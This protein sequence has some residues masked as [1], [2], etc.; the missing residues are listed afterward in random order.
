MSKRLWQIFGPILIAGILV[1]GALITPW[2]W[3]KV[4][5]ATVRRAAVSLSPTIL[6]GAR[7]KDQAVASGDYPIFGSSELARMDAFHPAVYAAKYQRT[8]PFLLGAAGTQ[9]LTHFVANQSLMPALKGKKAVVI[10]SVQWFTAQG[11]RADAFAYYFSPL[12]LINWL[13]QANPHDAGDRYAARRLLTMPSVRDGGMLAAATKLIQHGHALSSW[14]RHLLQIRRQFL[15]N[16]DALF[17]Q[18]GMRDNGQKIQRGR[19]VLPDVPSMAELRHLAIKT[20]EAHTTS[21]DFGI[22]NHFYKKR[23]SRGRLARLRGSQRHFDYR[24]SP[25][26]GDLQLLLQQFAANHVDVQFILPPVNQKWAAYTGLSLPHVRQAAAKIKQQLQQQGF[27]RVLDL[28]ADGDKPYFMED[29]IHL[30]WSGWVTVDH[31][32]QRFLAQPHQASY[33]LNPT[34]YSRAWQQQ[35]I[36]AT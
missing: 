36:S 14:Q 22:S 13:L 18:L 33:Q 19:R 8:Q 25:E 15:Q 17:S 1:V 31:A 27:Q 35:I 2:H 30:G 26:Y 9:S 3:G 20:G 23:L 21:N 24:R 12:Q 4:G 34:Y 7:V 5:H 32:I 28:S 11:Q 10:L 29:T 6:A 16:E